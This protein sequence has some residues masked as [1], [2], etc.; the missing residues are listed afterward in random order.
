MEFKVI[1][2]YM[3]SLRLP[4]LPCLTK[5]TKPTRNTF[6]AC[7]GYIRLKSKLSMW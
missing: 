7:L 1:L 3:V 6:K 4:R 2:T 5:E